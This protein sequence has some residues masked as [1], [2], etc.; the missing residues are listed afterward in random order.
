MYEPSQNDLTDSYDVLMIDINRLEALDNLRKLL[1][2]RLP[3]TQDV[4]LLPSPCLCINNVIFG[5]R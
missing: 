3:S 5:P 1:Q 4:T 2:S